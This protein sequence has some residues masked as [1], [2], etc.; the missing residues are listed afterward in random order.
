[1]IK[2]LTLWPFPNQVFQHLAR[3]GKRFVI[4]EMNRGQLSLELERVVGRGRVRGVH[5]ADG[6]LIAPGEI[7][8]AIRRRSTRMES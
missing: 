4:A 3:Q 5:R 6:Q 1:L 7:L 8:Q 2:L